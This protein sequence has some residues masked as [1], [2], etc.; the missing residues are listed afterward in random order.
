M[1]IELIS[2]IL[3]LLA[4]QGIYS[5]IFGTYSYKKYKQSSYYKITQNSFLST[6][7]NAGLAGEYLIYKNLQVFEKKDWKLL[8]NLYIPQKNSGTTEIDLILITTYGLF[9]IESKNYS[10][11]IFGDENQ[12]YWT[13]TLISKYSGIIKEKFYNPIKQNFFHI[14]H[15]KM[16]LKLDIPIY[17]LIVFSDNCELKKITLKSDNSKVIYN[18]ELK[19]TINELIN[20]IPKPILSIEEINMIYNK[21]FPYT[22]VNSEIR[23]AHINNIKIY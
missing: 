18:Y 15:L 23:N 3:I 17:S 9:V 6:I 5:L 19:F 20:T 1:N 7:F 13:Q 14:L 21:L 12:K 10:G 2:I 8:F 4:L 22:Q 16:L 11:W